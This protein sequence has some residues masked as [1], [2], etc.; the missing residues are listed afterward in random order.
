MD[1]AARLSRSHLHLSPVNFPKLCFV[2]VY[3]YKEL[4]HRGTLSR[5]NQNN[6]LPKKRQT[7]I[8]LLEILKTLSAKF[9][10][11]RLHLLSTALLLH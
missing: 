7:H 1:S 10:L 6:I 5:L 11:E 9:L 2:K 3:S 8:F 4:M